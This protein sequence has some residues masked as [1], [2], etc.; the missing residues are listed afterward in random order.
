MTQLSDVQ[1]F[2][3]ISRGAKSPDELHGLLDDICLEMGFDYFALLHHVD[4]REYNDQKDRVLTD[5]FIAL[6]TYP[7]YWIDK[8]LS[9]EVVN[10]DPVLL[11]SQRTSVGF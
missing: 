7:Q 5:E 8:Y 10:F 6:S 1:L 4:L 11:A 2:I 9:D 3:D